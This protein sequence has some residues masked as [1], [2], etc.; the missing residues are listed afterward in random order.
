MKSVGF[1]AIAGSVPA[2]LLFFLLRLVAGAIGGDDPFIDGYREITT[3]VLGVPLRNAVI[4]FI[5]GVTV[6]ALA[7]ARAAGSVATGTRSVPTSRAGTPIWR[8]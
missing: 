2:L 7:G 5:A 1:A 3:S 6:V 4:V 8:T